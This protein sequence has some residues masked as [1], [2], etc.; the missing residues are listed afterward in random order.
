MVKSAGRAIPCCGEFRTSANSFE[1]ALSLG[2]VLFVMKRPVT[3]KQPHC[4]PEND[5]GM[6]LISREFR[7]R[8]A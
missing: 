1:S 5:K 7:N 8:A 4:H 2:P 3:N 6:L